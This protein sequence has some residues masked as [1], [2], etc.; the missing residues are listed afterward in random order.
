M[1]DLLHAAKTLKYMSTIDLKSGYWQI[2]M[3]EKDKIKTAFTTPFGIF[4]FNR[5]PFGLKKAP[6]TFQSLV[7]KF[8]NGL[9]QITILAYL[10]DIIICSKDFDTHL[11]DLRKT[12][13][14]I[15]LFNLVL[16][17]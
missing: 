17:R 1:D 6:A 12:F 2:K 10:D 8:R 13:E 9:T 7:D 11:K 5:M 14:R 4:I 15:Q 16:N 3:F